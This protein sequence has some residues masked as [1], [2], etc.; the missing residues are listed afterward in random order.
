MTV[1]VDTLDQTMASG[2]GSYPS[3]LSGD[4][5][6]SNTTATGSVQLTRGPNTGGTIGTTT[7]MSMSHTWTMGIT[8]TTAGTPT[9]ESRSVSRSSSS[10]LDATSEEAA[11]MEAVYQQNEKCL[12]SHRSRIALTR[13]TFGRIAP[14]SALDRQRTLPPLTQRGSIQA[15]A[16]S[17]FKTTM[18]ESGV[19]RI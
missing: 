1:T 7:T 2:L 10:I 8:C 13:T 9:S 16:P 3:R 19:C 15:E 5:P 17:S 4:I 18:S 14:K 6:A 11:P 12:F